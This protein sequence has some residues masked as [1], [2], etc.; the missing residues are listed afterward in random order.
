[1]QRLVAWLAIL[2]L[3]LST[4]ACGDGTPEEQGTLGTVC[5]P[6]QACTGDLVCEDGICAKA[7]PEP[8]GYL[9]GPCYPNDTCNDDLVCIEFICVEN[10]G[11][12]EPG[13]LDGPC[14]GNNSCDAGLVCEASICR[15]G[16]IPDT[17]GTDVIADTGATAD[18]SDCTPGSGCLLD[19]CEE[20]DECISGICLLHEGNWVCSELC[21]DECPQGWSCRTI[22]T[23]SS[24]ALFAC[25]S[26]GS[27]LCLPCIGNSDC[28]SLESQNLCLDYGELGKFCG[29]ACEEPD[30]CPVGYVCEEISTSQGEI[31][32]QCINQDGNCACTDYAI[33]M[34]LITDCTVTNDYG[35][36]TG[37]RS[38]TNDGLSECN[39]A[40]PLEEI[41]DG[42]DNNCDGNMDEGQTLPLSD[43][44]NGLCAGSVK[45]CTG[46][47]GW[48]EPN[49]TDIAT[50]EGTET[51]CDGLDN[52][53][54]GT[55][56]NGL[57]PPLSNNQ[58]G[59]CGGSV[60]VCT[61][62]DGWTEPDYT[63][64]PDHEGT[65]TLCDGL[66][67][68]CDD[69]LDNGLTPPLSN[70]Q[71]GICGGSVKVCSGLDG[72][73][74]PDYT[75][76][77][78]H[79]GTETLCDGRDN[80][81]DDDVDNG[82][83]PPLSDNQ[84][85]IC[86][87]SVKVCS[88]ADGWTEPDYTAL[89]VHEGTETLCDSLDNDCDGTI[90][91]GLIPPISDNQNGLCAGSVKICSW[92]EG[93]TEPDYT[94]LPDH[95]DTETLCDG[96]DNDC[97]GVVDNGLTPP[98]SDN[99]TGV[100]AGATKSCSGASGWVNDYPHPEYEAEETQCD[101]LDNDCDSGVDNGLTPPLSNNQSGI[102]GGSVKV[103][104]ELDGWTEPDY[105]ILPNY[106]G[107]ETLCDGHDNDCDGADDNDLVAP[108]SDNQTGV[109]AGATKSCSG[110]SGWIN[111][112]PHP[113]Y[114]AEETQC[115]GLDNDCDGDTDD[116]CIPLGEL[117]TNPTI[118]SVDGSI[119]G[120]GD[121][122]IDPAYLGNGWYGY[123][124]DTH[125]GNGSGCGNMCSYSELDAGFTGGPNGAGCISWFYQ[126]VT[127]P[128]SF[129]AINLS[130]WLKAFD[131]QSGMHHVLILGDSCLTEGPLPGGQW[132]PWG[133]NIIYE[134][135]EEPFSWASYH[136]DLT[137]ELKAYKG[138]TLFIGIGTN[139]SW[140][141]NYNGRTWVDDVH[142]IAE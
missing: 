73:T 58:N 51:L 30:D 129:S 59:I 1:M 35:S 47:D 21:I 89:P 61:G 112:Y 55:V 7:P 77:P 137:E 33:S 118:N 67:N 11:V 141:A 80:D 125:P 128:N 91:N 14:Y 32:R 142:L 88:G 119:C 60:K 93:W 81:C 18:T 65:E 78:D 12:P 20:N 37:T 50:Y 68:D 46:A 74:E 3:V 109:C 76:L 136:V 17:I 36:C 79:E 133:A 42:L 113:E 103:C 4:G 121:S 114:E 45:V 70:N 131:S 52:D 25:I 99:Q 97:D 106:E 138:A 56:D 139:S 27:H 127:I 22:N 16:D 72:W 120:S 108:L 110:A 115:D 71:N 43:N 116:L 82:L 53:C 87:G 26:T 40:E 29:S 135:F 122:S 126:C 2:T 48:I 83:T 124:Q 13:Q 98:L 117:V 86:G 95:E 104:S 101:G 6:D 15:P 105:T 38:C 107:T 57:T 19:P 23:G 34:G 10:P 62:A 75:A 5:Y 39:A 134:N 8:Q 66:D 44:Q 94:A 102:C 92:L 41:C 24:D 69:V 130:F 64:L 54:D 132:A 63:A 84:N 9:N 28:S 100:C 49:Y 85:G 96:Y 90:D 123:V 111:D 31:A 140:S